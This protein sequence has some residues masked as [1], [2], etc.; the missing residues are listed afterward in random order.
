M[1][2]TC[3][4]WLGRL[5]ISRHFSPR[6]RRKALRL[7]GSTNQKNLQNKPHHPTPT[8]RPC[9]HA[10]PYLKP[11]PPVHL[12]PPLVG[13]DVLSVR[14]RNMRLQRWNDWLFLLAIVCFVC[15]PLG[16]AIILFGIERPEY[17]ELAKTYDPSTSRPGHFV[18]AGV[19]NIFRVVATVLG[20]SF[21]IILTLVGSIGIPRSALLTRKLR[22]STWIIFIVA[23]AACLGIS[24]L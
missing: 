13:V 21:G 19:T 11:S 12:P 18:S 1:C 8:S 24:V 7:Q 16:N 3:D 5:G 20:F 10:F 17:N 9:S 2:S 4:L 6:L 15:S 23:F 22:D 14:Q